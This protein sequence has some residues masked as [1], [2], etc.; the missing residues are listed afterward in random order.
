MQ[1]SNSWEKVS[2]RTNSL[3]ENNK[4]DKKIKMKTQEIQNYSLGNNNLQ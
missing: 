3:F 2:K 4:E 1:E